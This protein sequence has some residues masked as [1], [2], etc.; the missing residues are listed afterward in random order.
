MSAR[1]LIATVILLQGF[2][3]G[4][5]IMLGFVLMPIEFSVG[6]R[7]LT[8]VMCAAGVGA[9]NLLRLEIVN[10]LKGMR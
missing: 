7:L 8:L 1:D 2:T 9:A 3:L 4:A 6:A 5:G 10:D